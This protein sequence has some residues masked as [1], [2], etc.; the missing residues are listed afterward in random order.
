[1]HCPG[2]VLIARVRADE[3]RASKDNAMNVVSHGW[4]LI[5]AEVRERIAQE[6]EALPTTWTAAWDKG[7]DSVSL[8][9]VLRIAR[10]GER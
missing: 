9:E 2:C 4:E 8:A 1:M 7:W 5:E 6:I 10:G 3:V